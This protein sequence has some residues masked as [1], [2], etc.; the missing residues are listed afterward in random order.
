MLVV[1]LVIHGT[2]FA[3]SNANKSS[4]SSGLPPEDCDSVSAMFIQSLQASLFGEQ[5]YFT[6]MSAN[7]FSCAWYLNDSL[8]ATTVNWTHTFN[9]VRPYTI[10]LVVWNEDETCVKYY[11]NDHHVLSSQDTTNLEVLGNDCPTQYCNLVDFNA[12][13]CVSH[14]AISTPFTNNVTNVLDCW[15]SAIGTA[16]FVCDSQDPNALLI[17]PNPDAPA[18]GVFCTTSNPSLNPGALRMGFHNPYQDH[19]GSFAN[20]SNLNFGNTYFGE[21][22]RT[23]VDLSAGQPY[24]V[25]Y[26]RAFTRGMPAASGLADC[27]SQFATD[28]YNNAQVTSSLMFCNGNEANFGPGFNIGQLNNQFNNFQIALFNPVDRLIIEQPGI[29]D[30]EWRQVVEVISPAIAY[31]R[32]V[33]YA[34]HNLISNFFVDGSNIWQ[35]YGWY[36]FDQLEITE[37]DFCPPTDLSTSCNNPITIEAGPCMITNMIYE[38][39]LTDG[40]GNLLGSPIATGPT[41]TAN[42]N[43]TT[44][45]A[46]VRRIAQQ[47]QP[48]NNGYFVENANV[49]NQT[50]FTTVTVVNP[51][52]PQFYLSPTICINASYE[53]PTTSV[54]GFT[55]TWSPSFSSAALGATEYTFTTND[56]CALPYTITINVV[57]CGD[58]DN[59]TWPQLSGTLDINSNPFPGGQYRIVGNIEIEDVVAFNGSVIAI[60]PNVTIHVNNGATLNVWDSHLF[61]CDALWEGIIVEPEARLVTHNNQVSL[62]TTLIEDAKVAIRVLANPTMLSSSLFEGRLEI[63]HTTFNKNGVGILFWGYPFDNPNTIFALAGNVF[64]QR[65]VTTDPFFWPTTFDFGDLNPSANANNSENPRIN[66]AVYPPSGMAQLMLPDGTYQAFTGA[67]Y[68]ISVLNMGT[69]IMGASPTFN[70]LNI[71]NNSSL[72]PN[73]PNVFDG[74]T[75]GVYTLNSNVDV[76]RSI[77]QRGA[78]NTINGGI[79]GNLLLPNILY[80]GRIQVNST[81]AD[82]ANLFYNLQ[83]AVNVQGYSHLV[84]NNAVMRTNRTA[85]NPFLGDVGV[86][87]HSNRTAKIEILN[88]QIHNIN[89]GVHCLIGSNPS[90]PLDLNIS[91]NTIER[92]LSQ[93]PGFTPDHGITVEG[94][95][96][97]NAFTVYAPVPFRIIENTITNVRQGINVQQLSA[98][99]IKIIENDI[100]LG[101]QGFLFTDFNALHYGILVRNVSTQTSNIEYNQV[102]GFSGSLG[103]LRGIRVE[104]SRV[105]DITC[106]FTS[107]TQAGLYFF[108][109]CTGRVRNNTMNNHRYGLWLDG[110]AVIGTQGSPTLPSNNQW[111]GAWT[112]YAGLPP[113]PGSS[114][115]IKTFVSGLSFANFSPLFVNPGPVTNPI[116][117]WAWESSLN[118]PYNNQPQ[119]T[120]TTAT[121]PPGTCA[122]LLVLNNENVLDME[123]ALLLVEGLEQTA[124]SA[125]ENPTLVPAELIKEHLSFD[126]VYRDEE[127]RDSVEV[128]ETFYNE[129][130]DANMGK[131]REMEEKLEEHDVMAAEVLKNQVL[132]ENIIEQASKEVLDL[133]LNYEKDIF[134]ATDS[135]D[136]LMWATSCYYLYGK[137]VPMAQVLYNS[138]Y[139]SS[140]VFVEDCPENLPKSAELFPRKLELV[141]EL[142]PNPN[143]D[144]L[145]VSCDEDNIRSSNIV[146]RDIDGNIVHEG[147][148][149]FTKGL[150]L[151]K[152]NLAS[153]VY[154]VE[155]LFEYGGEITIQN[156]KLVYLK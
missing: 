130:L 82:D 27:S 57:N 25:S 76:T 19:G 78:E 120:Q 83:R 35:Q 97:N 3:A 109:N 155:L 143:R 94:L 40:N 152:L 79:G 88:N 135:L 133:R 131:L 112:P 95:S 151:S 65:T 113:A 37:N 132:A 28:Y 127:L 134:T 72:T 14:A 18:Q 46:I 9:E 7:Y 51:V 8:V 16:D 124:E 81:S 141:L 89:R 31:D 108:G 121:V 118:T 59:I 52:L 13:P 61:A 36:F 96:P 66:A 48:G 139:N 125:M 91:N 23:N 60:D 129:R 142:Y 70:S 87:F 137:A 103:N 12:T 73:N 47:G 38:W 104:N 44:T 62:K 71:Y 84:V 116:D 100:V 86:R 6:N 99:H 2:T 26:Y 33:V 136:L 30:T 74:L 49:L 144:M 68:G 145:Y 147:T 75:Y 17:P 45:Y 117:S 11:T 123:S 77:F 1:C 54:N 122:P 69:S 128:L 114:A 39:Y 93:L 119:I 153:G 43:V 140:T 29:N 55:G 126:Y 32:L 111:Q 154:I 56:P 110:G 53:L 50:C 58:C 115:R 5:V 63:Y 21:A 42:P 34:R 85:I 138:I 20:N 98:R 101:F 105:F 107:N 24:I 41:L 90:F 80:F 92:G 15:Q 4:K 150:D 22:V 148:I 102:L 67:K 156:K 149:H 106:N 146:I 10:K 64:S